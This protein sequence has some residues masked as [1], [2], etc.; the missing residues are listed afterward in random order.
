MGIVTKIIT[1]LGAFIQGPLFVVGFF[2][3]WILEDVGISYM[4]IQDPKEE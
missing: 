1:P 4:A 2:I 3:A